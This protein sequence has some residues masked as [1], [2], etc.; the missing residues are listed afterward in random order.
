MMGA[1]VEMAQRLEISVVAQGVE[2][3][4]QM[5]MLNALQVDDAQ[6]FLLSRPVPADEIPHLLA[7]G[8]IIDGDSFQK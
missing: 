4:D 6:G 5:A 8:P 3:W 1:V 7:N 2:T